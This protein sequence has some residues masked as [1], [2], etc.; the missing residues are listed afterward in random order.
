VEERLEDVIESAF[1]LFQWM[2]CESE[3]L[4][5]RLWADGE[6]DFRFWKIENDEK[7]VHYFG[8]RIKGRVHEERFSGWGA[9]D[10]PGEAVRDF[11][12]RLRRFANERVAEHDRLRVWMR[13][14]GHAT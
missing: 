11:R 5:Y 12:N 6:R 4:P 7:I 1:A 2:Y 9:G 14:N 10:T 8:Y 3:V 13:E